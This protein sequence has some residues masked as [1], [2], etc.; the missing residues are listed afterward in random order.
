MYTHIF[1]DAVAN[2]ETGQ[3]HIYSEALKKAGVLS[4]HERQL[5]DE[6][7]NSV[8]VVCIYIG[9]DELVNFVEVV[10]I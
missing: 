4:V 6:L 3:V 10:F 7:V 2:A 8:E 5:A 9:A 1:T